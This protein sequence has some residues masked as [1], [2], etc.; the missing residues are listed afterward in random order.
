[1][2]RRPE[3]APR[4]P[5]CGYILHGPPRLRCPECGWAPRDA[6]EVSHARSLADDNAINRAAVRKEW[7]AAVAGLVFLVAGVAMA[8]LALWQSPGTGVIGNYF[9][10][11][12][13]WV[14]LFIT[15][16]YLIYRSRIGEP[17]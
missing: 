10:I 3:S 11:R 14:S 15:A 16:G 4:C 17:M 1:M 12:N 8:A 5:H 6:D 9:P 13:F 7:I 2:S